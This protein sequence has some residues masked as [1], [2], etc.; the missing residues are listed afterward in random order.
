MIVVDRE[1]PDFE[2]AAYLK[3]FFWGICPQRTRSL[4]DY[5]IY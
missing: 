1:A 5:W 2:G 4:E 3:I